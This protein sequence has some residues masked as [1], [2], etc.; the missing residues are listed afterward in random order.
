MCLIL[1]AEHPLAGEC[2]IPPKKDTHVQGQRRSPNK[3]VGGVKSRLESNPSQRHLEGSNKALC[4]SGDPAET[5][6]DLPLSVWVLRSGSAVACCRG[7]GSGH[8]RPGYGINP[9]P[10]LTVSHID[11][12]FFSVLVWLIVSKQFGQTMWF[13]LNIWVSTP[14]PWSL[15]INSWIFFGRTDAEDEAPKLWRPD[16]KSQF[17][18]KGPD[19]G[20]DWGQEE[21]GATE[22][23]M[24]GWHY[25]LNGH[26]F[27]QTPGDSGG[28]R[29]LACCRP[30]SHKE[31]EL[32]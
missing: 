8:S 28:Q 25:Q 18:G 2:W 9:L 31:S 26:E 4:T 14:A 23:V 30:W 20:K 29:N 24:V 7:R 17:V 32:T 22:D 16:A 15:E 11:I 1:A 6:P 13:I 19:A 27:E 3:M 5:E 21:K 12:K 10:E